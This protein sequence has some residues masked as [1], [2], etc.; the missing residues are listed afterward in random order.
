[1][2]FSI[3]SS[4]S[5]RNRARCCSVRIGSG[6]RKVAAGL[7]AAGTGLGVEIVTRGL[8]LLGRMTDELIAM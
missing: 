3:T 2:R 6:L 8:L 7:P 1:L 5:G 4:S